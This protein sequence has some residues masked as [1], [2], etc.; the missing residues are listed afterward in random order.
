MPEMTQTV[1]V[2]DED[3]LA[4]VQALWRSSPLLPALLDRAPAAEAARSP[5]GQPLSLPYGV[6][7]CAPSPKTVRYTKSMRK[8][9]RK[10]TLTVWGTHEQAVA[11]LK[12]MQDVF[13]ARLGAPGWEHLVYQSG[14]KFVKWWPLNDGALEKEK[15]TAAAKAGEDVWRAIIEAEVTSVRY[16][17][18][19]RVA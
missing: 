10:V 14:A 8:D 3:T 13:H 5:L 17:A 19:A 1:D 15:G 11:A 2:V 6:L 4:A 18:G 9:V 16:D 12:A 7:S